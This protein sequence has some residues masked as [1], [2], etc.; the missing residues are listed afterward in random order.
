MSG[1]AFLAESAPA[2][3]SRRKSEMVTALAQAD[4]EQEFWPT[5]VSRISEGEFISTIAL[6][7]KVN[8][9]ILRN[10]IRGNAVREA[11][12]SQAEQDGKQ[13]RIQKVLKKVHETATADIPEETTRMEQLRAAEIAL[14][15]QEHEKAPPPRIGEINITFVSAKDGKPAEKVIDQLP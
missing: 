12:F 5:I 4:L 8:Y 2:K 1:N 7:L 3:H 13:V 9:S 15:V 10:W 14:R 6:E 11:E